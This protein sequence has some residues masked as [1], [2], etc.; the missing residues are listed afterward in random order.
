MDPAEVVALSAS[1]R[2]PP[3]AVE[4]DS[5]PL[6][7]AGSALV[8]ALSAGAAAVWLCQRW[9]VSDTPNPWGWILL[10]GLPALLAG[11]WGWRLAT[12]P[13][14]RLTWDGREW[15]LRPGMSWPGRTATPSALPPS[16]EHV[17]HPQVMIDLGGWMLLRLD[18]ASPALRDRASPRWVALSQNLAG[19]SWHGL[20]VALHGAPAGHPS[21]EAAPPPPP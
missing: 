4:L 19:A 14:W 20:R 7:R 15:R 18:S 5:E 10:S 1:R 12:V 16:A 17:C 11:W 8:S 2:P 13:A 6:W 9:M 3:A 21:P